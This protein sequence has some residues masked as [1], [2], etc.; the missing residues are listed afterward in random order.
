MGDALPALLRDAEFAG[1]AQKRIAQAKLNEAPPI[2]DEAVFYWRAWNE[3]SSDR[4][5]SFSGIAP[6]PMSA[7]LLYAE[8]LELTKRETVEFLKV[9]RA[10]DLR[11]CVLVRNKHEKQAEKNRSA[12]NSE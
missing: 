5:P 10:V 2:S 6:I 9:I 4:P 1:E 12:T 7:I 11:N 8:F 3:L